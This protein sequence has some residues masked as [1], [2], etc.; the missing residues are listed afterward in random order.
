MNADR[1]YKLTQA[2]LLAI[3]TETTGCPSGHLYALVAMQLGADLEEHNA[4]VA[5]LKKVGLIQES[6]HLL[7]WAGPEDLRSKLAAAMETPTGK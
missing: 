7:T 5:A 6:M 3:A 1:I 2:Y 4:A